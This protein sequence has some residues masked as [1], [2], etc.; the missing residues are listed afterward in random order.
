MGRPL[1]K[2]YFGNRNIGSTST[3][4]DDKIGGKS[5]AS[6]TLN[7]LGSYTTRPTVTFPAPTLPTGVTALGTITS[8]ALSGAVTTAGT[9]YTVGDL[10][11]LT[12][13]GG[14]AIAYVA[15]VDTGGEILTVNFTGT[16]ASRGSFEALPGAKFPSTP[17]G[18]RSCTGGTGTG[19]EITVTFRAKAVAISE[20][21]SGYVA[22]AG[23]D[24]TFTQSVTASAV[25]FSTDSGGYNGNSA[26]NVSTNQENALIFYAKTTSGGTAQAGDVIKQEASRRYKII[27]ADG[28][29]T[30]KL[31]ASNSPA[32]NECYLIATDQGGAT[33]WVTKLTAHKALLTSTGSGTPQFAD[34]KS[35]KWLLSGAVAN[36]SV[37]IE[38]A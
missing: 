33:Y 7:A 22:V 34:G 36:E 20:S 5:I 3:T 10:L 1:N 8:E 24:L 15:S 13:N 2:K 32:V 29:A 19:A 4:A 38:N 16:G 12:S 11:T 6:V 21:G 23:G 27:T 37:T 14:S 25:T 31:V 28:T 18:G 17:T 35:V 9:G 26:Q 30:C